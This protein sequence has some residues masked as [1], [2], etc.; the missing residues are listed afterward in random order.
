MRKSLVLVLLAV[1]FASGGAVALTVALA[2]VMAT[3]AG[4]GC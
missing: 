4:P 3:C 1:V 2:P